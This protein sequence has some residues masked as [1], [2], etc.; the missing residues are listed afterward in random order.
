MPT[1]K[2]CPMCGTGA[3]RQDVQTA[4]VYGGKPGQAFFHCADCEI[5]YQFPFLTP[6]EE[7]EFYALEYE[8]FMSERSANKASWESCDAHVEAETPQVE[9]RKKYLDSALPQKGRIL[10]VGCS[11]GCM[12]YPLSERG[13]ECVGIEPSKV[14]NEYV[15]SRDIPCFESLEALAAD[16]LGGDGF[17]VIIHFFVL[18]HVGHPIE[19]INA[20]LPLLNKGGKLIIE[21]PNTADALSTVYDIPEFERFFWSAHHP[22]YYSEIAFRIFLDRFDREY[23]IILDQRY[24]LSNHMV[25]AR[26]RKPGG[27]GRFTGILGEE[28]EALYKK[29]LIQAGKCDTLVAILHN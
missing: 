24:D 18:E 17:D 5:V 22:W 14:F 20:Q 7:A 25:W 9:R 6:E 2:N 19:F 21:V 11:S 26:D 12:L 16:P 3:D 23:E 13:Y 8:T 15:R 29:G 10:E 28:L 27:T 4:H 1:P